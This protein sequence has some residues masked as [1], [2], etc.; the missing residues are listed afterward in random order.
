MS[1]RPD[2]SRAA[3]RV[4][5]S[6]ACEGLRR[7]ARTL[8]RHY[9]D[10]LSPSGLR[11][12]Q[13]PILVGLSVAG[14]LPM[15]PLADALGMDRTTLARNVKALEER[16][17]VAVESDGEDRRRRVLALTPAGEQALSQALLLWAPTQ[18]GVEDRFGRE[19]LHALLGELSSLAGAVGEGS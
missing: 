17:L 9:D 12:T 19:R 4:K 18:A 7:A 10:A 8:T 2:L 11:V 15:T 1:D 5:A 6:C 3:A 16:A 14:P 13:L